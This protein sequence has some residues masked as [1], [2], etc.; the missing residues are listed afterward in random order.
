MSLVYIFHLLKNHG[1]HAK[2]FFL[3]LLSGSEPTELIDYTKQIIECIEIS[4][5]LIGFISFL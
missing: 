5:I 4:L 3:E 1:Y 2:V